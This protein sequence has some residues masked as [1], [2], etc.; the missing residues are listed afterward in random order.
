MAAAAGWVADASGCEIWVGDLPVSSIEWQGACR[1]GRAAGE[2]RLVVVL[3]DPDEPAGRELSCACVASDGRMVGEGVIQG[4][5]FGRYEGDLADGV[6]HGQGDRVY[7][8]GERYE[9]GWRDG[10]RHGEG[11]VVSPRGWL[12][13]GGFAKDVFSGRGRSEWRNGDWHEGAYLGGLRHGPGTYASPT[14]GWR[15]EGDFV[16]G[17]REGQGTLFLDTGHQFTGAFKNGKPDGDG[18]CV[19]PASRK[20]GACRYGLGRFKEWLD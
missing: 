12:Y 9:G 5:G 15:Y 2:G 13:R 1:Q 6:P 20:S 10:A 7:G 4:P 16:K 14:A 11:E 19:D 8:S 17:V 18:V 3:K